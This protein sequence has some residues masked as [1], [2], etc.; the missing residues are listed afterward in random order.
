MKEALTEKAFLEQLEALLEQRKSADAEQS[1]VAGMYAGGL[2]GLL[3]K[4]NEE[5]GEMMLAS[6]D[7]AK[8]P[9]HR[10]HL[11]HEAADV[12]FH[13]LLVLTYQDVRLHEVIKVLKVR[14]GQSGLQEKAGRTGA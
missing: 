11:L 3:L 6:Q 5:V 9:K 4:L 10:E 14:E 1:Y 2:Q 8:A 13:W 12:L 7:F